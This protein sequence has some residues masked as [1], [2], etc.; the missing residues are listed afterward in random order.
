MVTKS[1]NCYRLKDISLLPPSFTDIDDICEC[2]AFTHICDRFVY[3]I[4][5]SPV[6]DIVDERN[7]KEWMFANI[8]PVLPLSISER[9]TLEEILNLAEETFVS[10]TIDEAE[11]FANYETTTEFKKKYIS[12]ESPIGCTE[13]VINVCNRLKIGYGNNI[14]LMVGNVLNPGMYC[15]LVKVGVS[16]IRLGLN[17]DT[18]VCYPAASLI[19]AFYKEKEDYW[20]KSPMGTEYDSLPKIIADTEIEDCSDINKAIGLGA[21][22]V[23]VGKMF[24][25]CEEAIGEALYAKDE[26]SYLNGCGITEEE[27]V[28]MTLKMS[29]FRLFNGEA[30][31]VNSRIIDAVSKI[32]NSL[33]TCMAQ[34]GAYNI[35]SFRGKPTY[36]INEK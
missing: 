6:G 12:I 3:P 30:V 25:H 18:G 21:D 19:S 22:A 31:E 29:K 32:G 28:I 20:Y 9:L 33:R 7:Y 36:L 1:R 17:T 4:F 15:N 5:V 8:T 11:E 10:L 26:E 2:N 34:C 27:Y 13:S 23:M 16:W 35:D 14:E 24:A